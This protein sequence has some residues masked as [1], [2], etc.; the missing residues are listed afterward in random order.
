MKCAALAFMNW[1]CHL[2]LCGIV[3][4][5]CWGC[6]P[7]KRDY[8][9]AVR[10]GIRKVPH[11]DEICRMFPNAPID[12]FITQYGFDKSA[13]VMW[14]TEVFFGGRYMLTY[15]IYVSMDYSQNRIKETTSNPQFVLVE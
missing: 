7:S 1:F 3:A 11:V 4:S 8:E 13:P 5:M 14:N 10:D 6:S 2:I 9:A 12:H 15:Q